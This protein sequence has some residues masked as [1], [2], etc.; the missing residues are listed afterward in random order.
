MYDFNQI[1]QRGMF[2][3]K[4]QLCHSTSLKEDP[5]SNENP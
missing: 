2:I 4:F 3:K 5:G 1:N